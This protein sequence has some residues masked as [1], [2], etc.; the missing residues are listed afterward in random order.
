MQIKKDTKKDTSIF[1][2]TLFSWLDYH[3]QPKAI[4]HRRLLLHPHTDPQ[5]SENNNRNS[6]ENRH[7]HIDPDAAGKNNSNDGEHKESDD[8]DAVVEVAAE[9]FDG[10]VTEEEEEEPGDEDGK[11]DD[12]GE[13]MPQETEEEDQE[14]DGGVVHAEVVEVA[15]Q[16]ESGFAE[17]VRAREG[18]EGEE[19][20]PWTARGVVGGCSGAWRKVRES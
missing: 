8:D 1:L 15:L 17:G 4:H 6:N 14:D 7:Q 12:E 13:R 19:F 3:Q 9:E 16:A 18:V 5:Y 20:A 2:C 11:E 10:T